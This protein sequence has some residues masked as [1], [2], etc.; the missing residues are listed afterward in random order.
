M[1]SMSSKQRVWY[2]GINT[3]CQKEVTIITEAARRDGTLTSAN[4]TS[5]YLGYCLQER[6]DDIVCQKE[7]GRRT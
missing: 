4:V 1:L 7:R 3:F 6:K 5:A 2:R